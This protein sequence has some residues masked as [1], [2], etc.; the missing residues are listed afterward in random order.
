MYRSWW[1]RSPSALASRLDRVDR[2]IIAPHQR[3][4]LLLGV[5]LAQRVADE[6]LVEV[7]PPQ[8][9]VAVELDPVHVVG[10]ALLPVE[11]RPQ[12]RER[13]YAGIVL[14]HR[15]LEPQAMAMER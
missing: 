4:A 5:V 3:L 8:V 1:T 11:R 2:E 7:D 6:L 13:R 10:L 15:A 14:G 9:G 12:R